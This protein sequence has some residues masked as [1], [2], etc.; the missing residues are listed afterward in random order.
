[1]KSL[2]AV[3]WVMLIAA[4][5][6]ALEA[7][8]APPTGLHE[9]TITLKSG[10]QLRLQVADGYTL[11]PV[12][13]GLR[14]PRFMAMS[15]DGRLFVGDMHAMGDNAQGVVHVLSGFDPT[16]GRAGKTT[17]WLRRLRNPHS[18]AFHADAQGQ[19]WLYLALTDGLYRYPYRAGETSPSAPPQRIARFPDGGMSTANGGWHLTRTVLFA[20]N[21]KLNVSV[22]SSCNACIE[23]EAWRA[24]VLEMNPD[25]SDARVIAR[26]VRNAVGMAWADGRLLAGNQGADHL[27]PD[28]PDETVIALAAGHD[29]GWPHCYW[30]GGKLIADPL[31]PRKTGCNAVPKPF[32]RLPAH[33]SVLGLAWMARADNPRLGAHL[34]VALHGSG[35]VRLGRGYRVATLDANGRPGPVLVDGFLR[36]GRVQGRPAGVL[37]I[38]PDA[39]LI[40]DDRAGV[41]YHL[42]PDR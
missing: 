30:R 8:A 1:M 35:S 33:S 24:V 4:T 2:R 9:Q 29:H 38:G 13:E 19:H 37:R 20:P 3:A 10:K 21:G 36:Q 11:T 22:G 7:V 42:R 12:L 6:L 25:G 28:A 14:R 32:A 17:A 27:G 39:L 16:S 5:L 34:V 41:V 31:Y 15:P 23:K 26:G 18:L 40:S